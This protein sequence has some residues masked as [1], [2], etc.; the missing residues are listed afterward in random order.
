MEGEGQKGDHVL[1]ERGRVGG[2]SL[3]Y[4]GLFYIGK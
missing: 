3:T 4:P 2:A 1:A